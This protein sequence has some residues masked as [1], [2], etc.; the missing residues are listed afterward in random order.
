[1]MLGH[2][3]RA[4]A[5]QAARRRT[6]SSSPS[7]CSWAWRC[8]SRPSRCWPGSSSSGGCSSGRSAR[9][10]LACAAIDDVTAWFLIALAT[11]VATSGTGGEVVAHDRAGDRLLPVDGA[12]RAAAARPRLD[13]LR[14]GRA[15]ARR[16]DRG[17]LRRRAA[18]RLHHRG[19]RHRRDLRRLHHG[20]DHAAPRGPDRGRDAAGSRTSSSSCCCRCSSPTPACGP[21]SA[22]S[23]GRSCG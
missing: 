9:S 8:R 3:G 19:D 7:R 11:A 6:R 17:D 14:R 18:V 1:M 21:T 5:L 23:T 13:R 4:A 2:R 16:L 22:C 10:T 15:R 20:H 12:P